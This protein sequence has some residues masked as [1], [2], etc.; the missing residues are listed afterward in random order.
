MNFIDIVFPSDRPSERLDQFIAASF[1]ELSRA[2]VHRLIESGDIKVAGLQAKPSMKLKGGERISVNMPAPEA[3]EAIPEDIPLDIL[4]EDRDVVVI[5]KPAG[6][7]VHPGAGNRDGTLVNAL[8]GHCKDLSG[9]G[10]SMRPGIVHRID[11]DTSGVII[12]AK[13]DHSHQSLAMQ[14]KE[15]TIKRIY[16]ALVFGSPKTDS[17]HITSAIGRHPVDR[18][19]MSSKARHGK[20]AVTHWQVVAR[21]EGVT[22]LKLRLETGRTHQIRVHLSEAGYPL[23]GDQLYGSEGRLA[24]IRNTRVRALLKGLT[25]QGLHAKTLGFIHPASGQYMEFDTPLPE[26]M[27]HIVAQ[28]AES[29]VQ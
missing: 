2:M 13:N 5:N 20:Q 29:T 22:L 27:N 6:M 15:H 12:A 11:K 28:L 14:F 9:I 8:L 10:G 1:A 21:Y 19:K 17:G 7:V 24:S 4:F 26:D 3:C 18:K 25:R 23:V 16:L